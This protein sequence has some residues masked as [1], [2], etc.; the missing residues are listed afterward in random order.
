VEVL[1][2]RLRGLGIG[3][4]GGLHLVSSSWSDPGVPAGRLFGVFA[5]LAQSVPV[6]LV[7]GAAV[8]VGLDVVDVPR[9]V[10]PGGEDELMFT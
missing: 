5:G 7:G 6:G 2:A 4:G 1:L 8:L 3:R 10:I 9:V